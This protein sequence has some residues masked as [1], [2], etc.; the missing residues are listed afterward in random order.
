MF[1]PSGEKSGVSSLAGVETTGRE[2][3]PAT[4]TIE[5]SFCSKTFGVFWCYYAIALESGAQSMAETCTSPVASLVALR[6]PSESLVMG[7]T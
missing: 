2:G 1:C 5:M 4:R 6:L 7:T 3:P